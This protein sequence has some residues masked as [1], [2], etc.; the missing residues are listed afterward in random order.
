VIQENYLSVEQN[1]IS[2]FAKEKNKA[3]QVAKQVSE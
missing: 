1:S 3:R 2:F